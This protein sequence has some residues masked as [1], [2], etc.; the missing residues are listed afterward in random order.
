LGEASLLT[1]KGGGC[2]LT[3]V[4]EV[5]PKRNQTLVLPLQRPKH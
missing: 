3:V 1:I 4:G 5:A 2:Y